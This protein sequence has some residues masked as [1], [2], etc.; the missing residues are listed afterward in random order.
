MIQLI[1]RENSYVFH[2]RWTRQ[3]M[4][5]IVVVAVMYSLSSYDSVS[6]HHT[7][8][9]MTQH[10]HSRLDHIVEPRIVEP[11]LAKWARDTGK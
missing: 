9:H 7:A 1:V 5:K 2:L 3:R 10:I 8:T 6:H 4:H 11:S